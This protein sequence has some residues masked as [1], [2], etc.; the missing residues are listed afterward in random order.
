MLNLSIL[1]M[2]SS[3]NIMTLS[4][5][6][7][8]PPEDGGERPS[9]YWSVLHHKNI[10]DTGPLHNEIE[11]LIKETPSRSKVAYGL[12]SPTKQEEEEEEGNGISHDGWKRL[13]EMVQTRE[14]FIHNIPDE[15]NSPMSHDHNNE[16][17]DTHKPK[18][19]M[20]WS[21]LDEISYDFLT[22]RECIMLTLILLSIGV[23][24][25]SILVEEWTVLDSL[26][27]TLVMLTTI[28]YGDMTPSRPISKLFAAFFALGGIIVLGLALGVLG[29][30]LVEAEVSAVEKMKEKATI[31]IE[32]A[33]TRKRK[34]G[35][36]TSDSSTSLSSLESSGSITSHQGEKGDLLEAILAVQQS[37]RSYI[38]K[39]GHQCWFTLSKIQKQF[40][41][42]IIPLFSGAA[43]IAYLEGWSVINAFYYSVVT[44]TTIGFGDLHP[45]SELTKFCAIIFI[46]FAVGVTGYIMGQ[47]ASF[48]IELRRSDHEKRL[49]TCDIKLEDL[50]ALD[51]N[52]NGGVSELEYIRFMLVAMKKVD[53]KLFDELHDQFRQLDMNH[54]GVVT[55]KDLQLIAARKLRKVSYKLQLSDY[56]RQLY[57]QSRQSMMKSALHLMTSTKRLS[58]NRRGSVNSKSKT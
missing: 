6:D 14:L 15:E 5:N 41:Y 29:S 46:P 25:F 21:D 7:D 34:N 47:C 45:T 9:I 33:F 16:V 50:E 24:G 40:S 30:Q 48:L 42:G 43:L 57:R 38:T 2:K 58:T 49:W 27:F 51:R 3:K 54:D 22:V 20:K 19:F 13:R 35:L 55:K 37:E 18:S 1:N 10:G 11:P 32:K 12:A 23:V 17:E 4:D 28:G 56:K 36:V 53:G 8:I 44:A 31:S 52:H 26:Y 39:L